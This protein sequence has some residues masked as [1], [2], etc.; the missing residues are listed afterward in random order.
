ME[1][2]L[3]TNTQ[4][5]IIAAKKES[6]WLMDKIRN[7]R[8]HK[9]TNEERTQISVQ[10][11]LKQIIN[12]DI[13]IC[14][15]FRKDP[16]KQSIHEKNQRE[17]LKQQQYPDLIKPS[18]VYIHNGQIEFGKGKKK[19]PFDATKTFDCYSPSIDRYGICKYTT[20]NGGAQDNQYK[21]VKDFLKQI[22]LY[23]RNHPSSTTTFAFYL[24]G[25][26]YNQTRMNDMCQNVPSDL[27]DKIE[28]TS[29]W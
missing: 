19:R 17:Q 16:S 9:L 6:S 5:L 21:D 12:H 13:M 29:V 15:I 20:Q 25:K 7:Y 26:Y 4:E 28:I 2:H 11:I 23:Y 10:Y 1:K 18:A 14:S 27:K 3:Y 8:Q 22:I 24:D